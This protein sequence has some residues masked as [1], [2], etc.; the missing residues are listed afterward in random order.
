M[1]VA[2]VIDI[3]FEFTILFFEKYIKYISNMKINKKMPWDKTSK[4]LLKWFNVDYS[5]HKLKP[6]PNSVI[7]ASLLISLNAITMAISD[8]IIETLSATDL[9]NKIPFRIDFLSLT[10]LSALLAL[11]TVK[12]LRRRELDIT[13]QAISIG[14]FVEISLIIGDIYF[15]HQRNYDNYLISIRLPFI[16]LTSVNAFLLIYIIFRTN[17]FQ[18][19]V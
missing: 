10:F 5:N 15:L 7:A 19:N 9:I 18:E 1:R 12:G 4:K 6:I 17:L 2:S 8:V 16:L 11:Q 14:L 13:Q 3:Q